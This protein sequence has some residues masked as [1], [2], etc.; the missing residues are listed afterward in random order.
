VLTDHPSP[1]LSGPGRWRTRVTATGHVD[2]P[3]G[4][5]PDE[6]SPAPPV[7]GSQLWVFTSAGVLLANWPT[8]T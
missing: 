2:K 6:L 1:Y 8:C 4:Y 3:A 7:I 5:A